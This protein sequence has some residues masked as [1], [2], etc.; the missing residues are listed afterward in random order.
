MKQNLFFVYFEP[1][2]GYEKKELC[3]E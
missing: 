1:F 3:A 2:C